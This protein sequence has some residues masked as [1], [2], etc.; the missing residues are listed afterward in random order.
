MPTAM[1]HHQSGP[2]VVV[3]SNMDGLSVEDFETASIRS[4][5]PSYVSD[6]PSYHSAL[7]HNEP[8]P[9]YSPPERPLASSRHQHGSSP[10]SLLAPAD[11]NS[12]PSVGL[13]PVPPAPPRVGVGMGM[14]MGGM[15]MGM[16]GLAAGPAP[17]E[18]S[19]FR[20][21]WSSSLR[22]NNPAT[23]H[24]R[25]VAHRRASAAVADG[26]ASAARARPS[27]SA[28]ALAEM[29]SADAEER[30]R[31]RPLE[32]P[33]LVGEEAARKARAERLARENGDSILQMEDRR[34]DLFLAQMRT[35]DGGN[36]R[37]GAVARRMGMR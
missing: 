24:Y 5:A 16:M 13:P 33:Y 18:L 28:A 11:S 23:R 21:P 34:W 2:R 14:G 35:W 19:A 17:V 25:N 22:S 4:A 32:D 1:Q 26:S 7:P 20:L 36:R 10:T 12:A 29:E 9:P 30:S 8:T 27:A 15:G 37:R 31:L 3:S 6:V